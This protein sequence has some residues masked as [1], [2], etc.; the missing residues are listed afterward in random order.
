MGVVSSLPLSN[1]QLQALAFIKVRPDATQKEIAEKAG[2]CVRTIQNWAKTPEW[3]ESMGM[4]PEAIL[5]D[6]TF[7]KAATG[8]V[9][10]LDKF[11]RWF[12]K[13]Q[14]PEEDDFARALNMT[15]EEQEMIAKEAH[16]Y[17]EGRRGRVIEPVA[18]APA[19]QPAF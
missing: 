16:A 6:T 9:Q 8:D 19:F 11:M 4:L 3:K 14:K 18:P 15:D 7:L 1:A 17:I 13:E 10:A 2:V 12:G 5:K